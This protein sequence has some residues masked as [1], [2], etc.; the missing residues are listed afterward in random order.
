MVLN[1][2]LAAYQFRP[3][4]LEPLLPIVRFYRENGQ[5]HLGH[6]FACPVVTAVYPD[7]ILFIER[8]VYEYELPLEYARCCSTLGLASEAERM[9]ARVLAAPALPEKIRMIAEKRAGFD[10]TPG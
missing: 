8:R 4:R 10:L 3:T 9:Y 1:G 2:Y 7:D 5:A 6:L